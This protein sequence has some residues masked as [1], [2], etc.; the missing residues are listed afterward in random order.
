VAKKSNIIDI[1][2]G[3]SQ[4]A[5]NAYDG[6]LDEKGEPLKV[7][8]KR[9][10][11]NPMLDKRVMD[12]F[13]VCISGN[14]LIIRYHGEIKLK[15]VYQGDFEGEIA[16]RLQ[17]VASYLKKEYKKV[18]GN[19]LTLSKEDKEPNILVQSMSRIRSWVQASQKFKIGGIPEEPGVGTTVEERLDDTF[20][21]FLGMGKDKFPSTKKPENVK[22]KRDEEPPGKQKLSEGI[23]KKNLARALKV[24]AEEITVDGK[25]IAPKAEAWLRKKL[26]ANP[27]TAKAFGLKGGAKGGGKA[28]AKVEDSPVEKAIDKVA[29]DPEGLQ[30]ALKSPKADAAMDAQV[31]K[32]KEVVKS[33]FDQAMEGQDALQ[34]EIAKSQK[35]ALEKLIQSN[36]LA[37]KFRA[38]PNMDTLQ[39]FQKVWD[40]KNKVED[41]ISAMQAQWRQDQDKIKS[42]VMSGKLEEFL[43]LINQKRS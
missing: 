33:A 35:E 37:D 20:K 12:G 14:M 17:D 6:A 10:D 13:N 9:E 30:K 36:E 18:T 34:K 41:E 4:A 43:S 42:D 11:G 2:N 31:E 19:S 28:P 5:S 26:S 23:D 40:E 7:G 1:V 27:K 16:Q 29:D 39:A 24:I 3:I 15:E 25:K 38:N 22:G 32:E 21:K 8:L